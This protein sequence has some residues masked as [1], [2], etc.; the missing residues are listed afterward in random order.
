VKT[1]ETAAI[2]NTGVV[3]KC[4]GLKHPYNASPKP[5]E[6]VIFGT[7]WSVWQCLMLEMP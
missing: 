2:L 7:P 3:G 4:S 1:F 6:L 5:G